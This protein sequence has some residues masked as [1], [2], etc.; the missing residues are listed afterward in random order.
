MIA[1]WMLKIENYTGLSIA[2]QQKL[3]Y[4][5]AVFALVY[6]LRV[7]LLRIV[8]QSEMTIRLRY[9]WRKT[10][11][12]ASSILF[13]LIAGRIWLDGISNLM[14]Y[15]GLLS[16][17]VA[18]A[19][20]HP[21]ENMAGWWFILWKRPFEVGDRIQVG[22]QR[23]DVIDQR[24]M[25]FSLMEIGNWVDA[26]QST[27]RV[28]HI[29]NGEVFRKTIANY[30]HGFRYIWN[31]IP[32]LITFESD[33]READKILTEI[34][35]KHSMNIS[36][37]AT[38]DMERAAQKYLIFYQKLTPI[39]YTSAQDSGVLLTLRYLCD[40][41]NRRGTEHKLWRHILAEFERHD[42]INLAYQTTRFY[43]ATE[44]SSPRPGSEPAAAVG[45][46]EISDR[47]SKKI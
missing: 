11:I 31:E 3:L 16:A 36:E 7:I 25:M 1:E 44:E 39:V 8:F 41:R 9:R 34:V 42:N 4:T 22:E 30:H 43:K 29:P 10:T 40:P 28:I 33:W 14:T 46:V 37:K 47:D 35:R 12:Y 21:I 19:L 45:T 18:V 13:L 17:G 6:L 24:L 27:G 5:L 2:L 20:K 15:M 26:E 32:V 23:G 38:E